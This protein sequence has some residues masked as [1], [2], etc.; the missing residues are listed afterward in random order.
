MAHAESSA[1][2]SR[3]LSFLQNSR[4]LRIGISQAGSAG[5]TNH[6]LSEFTPEERGIV[7]ELIARAADAVL[8]WTIEGAAVAMNRYNK[9]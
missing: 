2:L 7:E 6:V 4:R 5:A 1:Y 3:F 8:A 9:S